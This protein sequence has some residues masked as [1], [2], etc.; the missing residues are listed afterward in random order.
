MDC[1]R[2]WRV[3]SEISDRTRGWRHG[4]PIEARVALV[5]LEIRRG[6]RSLQFQSRV[7]FASQDFVLLGTEGFLEFFT[8]KFDWNAKTLELLPNQHIVSA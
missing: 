4:T 1:R 5:N 3:A 8:A 7:H 6:R 2:H